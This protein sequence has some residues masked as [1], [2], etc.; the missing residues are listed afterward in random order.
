MAR[1]ATPV[2]LLAFIGIS[3]WYWT[4]P[5]EKSAN[6]VPVDDPR[7]NSEIMAKC[8]AQETFSI[9]DGTRPAGENPE[10]QC[11]DQYGFTNFNGKWYHR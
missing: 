8:I 9:E 4:G 10:E 2:L 5:Y 11:A 7:K 6:T 3:Y 1:L